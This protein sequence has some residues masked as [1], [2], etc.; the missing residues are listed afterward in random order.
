[1][2][3]ISALHSNK[4]CASSLFR[5][6]PPCWSL[7]TA[8]DKDTWV[9]SEDQ[10]WSYEAM[11]LL[12]SSVCDIL[13]AWNWRFYVI[14][15]SQEKHFSLWQY[16]QNQLVTY[17][18]GRRGS[19]FKLVTSNPDCVASACGTREQDLFCAVGNSSN[20]L[21]ILIWF[22][23]PQSDP[24]EALSVLAHSLGLRVAYIPVNNTF[25]KKSFLC[26]NFKVFDILPFLSQVSGFRFFFYKN[27]NCTLLHIFASP[28]CFREIIGNLP[29]LSTKTSVVKGKSFFLLYLSFDSYI[30]DLPSVDTNFWGCGRC[31]GCLNIFF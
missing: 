25:L 20:S 30:H 31:Q 15:G 18:Q 4:L 21:I 23:F 29:I 24:N 11:P 28:L 7:E 16:L 13:C 3:T 19:Y 5:S 26:L 27:Y 6:T 12:S 1:M 17:T 22:C 9:R 8:K 2:K 10:S 14:E